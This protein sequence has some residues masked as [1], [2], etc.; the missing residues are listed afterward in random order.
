MNNKALATA[1]T[2]DPTSL[3]SVGYDATL[4]ADGSVALELR[5]RWQGSTD[6]TRYRSA[7]DTIDVTEI[8]PSDPD[9]DAEAAL[10]AW[11]ATFDPWEDL[12]CEQS[13]GCYGFRRTR[14]GCIV[15]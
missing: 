14:A 9:N 10:T 4:Y 1:Q 5:S 2:Y 7:P 15:R 11:L 13:A 3:V 6:G 12:P 8:D